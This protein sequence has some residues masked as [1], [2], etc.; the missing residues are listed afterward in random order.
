MDAWKNGLLLGMAV[1]DYEMGAKAVS[2]AGDGARLACR[3]PNAIEKVA[4]KK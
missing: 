3:E 2:A 1:P 4:L